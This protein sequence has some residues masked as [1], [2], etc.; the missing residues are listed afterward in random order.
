VINRDRN[1][2]L[3]YLA[4]NGLNVIQ[5][6]VIYRRMN[7]PGLRFPGNLFTGSPALLATLAEHIEARRGLSPF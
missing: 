5:S 6:D 7:F 3:Q 2:R 4:G 1:L